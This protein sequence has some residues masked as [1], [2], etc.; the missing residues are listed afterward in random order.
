M[1]G[2]QVPTKNGP[3]TYA[4]RRTLQM[5]YTL[6]DTTLLSENSNA[7]RWPPAVLKIEKACWLRTILKEINSI[8]HKGK[9]AASNLSEYR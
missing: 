6:Q 9:Y 8:K 5:L 3:T 7:G 1:L 2:M 4:C